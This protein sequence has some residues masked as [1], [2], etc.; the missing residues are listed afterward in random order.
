[1]AAT[2]VQAFSGDLDIA[3]A[4]T[5]NLEV[6][7]ANLFVDTVSGRVGIGV[8]NPVAAFEVR[9]ADMDGEAVGT[10]QVI[11]RFSAGNDGILNV[12]AVATANG[13]ETL[14]LQTQID[15]RAFE[16]DV[17]GGWDYGTVSRHDFVLQ[18]YKG[19]VGIG[20]TNPLTKLYIQD[21]NEDTKVT[22]R[23]GGPTVN[24]SNVSI[25]MF[26][27]ASDFYGGMIQYA[28]TGSEQGLRLGHFVNSATPRI[29]M[30]IDRDTGYVGV[31][32]HEPEVPLDVKSSNGSTNARALQLRAGDVTTNSDSFQIL[33]G[34]AG[35]STY[36]HGISSNH[37]GSGG[38]Y[39]QLNFWTW[40][41]GQSTTAMPT[42]R[43]MTLTGNGR[44]G[45]NG[46]P[47]P[48]FN[49]D[50]N[51]SGRVTAGM[52]IDGSRY[53][54]NYAG[55]ASSFYHPATIT[56][57]P[58][59][60]NY[61]L[62]L[63]YACRAQAYV[64]YSDRR[65][66]ENIEDIDDASALETL[67]RLKPKKYTYKDTK[68]RGTTPVWGFIAQEVRETLP[69]ATNLTVDCI[70]NIYELANVSQSNVI[71]F[72]NFNTSNFEN[73][74]P[75]LKL[76]TKED[77]VEYA[78]VTSII[79]GYSVSVDKDLSE[80]SG[81][82]DEATSNVV[83]GDKIFVYGEEVS[84]FVALNKDAIFTVATSAVQELDR[85]LQ[86]E[87]VKISTLETQLASVLTRLD[88]LEGA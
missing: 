83:T 73:S 14:G 65:I 20:T 36:R 30:K 62:T 32:V 33:F 7:T 24:N 16:T 61:T 1:M 48:S 3:G 78:N 22:I 56:V 2:N 9:A 6:G 38:T 8:T 52:Y 80:W 84:D 57:N 86:A 45:I 88:T 54:A 12:F 66:K 10:S 55:E 63:Q 75:T 81:Q 82:Y 51:G 60:Y 79:D 72:T 41:S 77:N 53:T 70:P 74:L 76:M 71:T 47:A 40:Q 58:A 35:T 43:T 19:N 11:S 26:E 69:H 67:R 42:R 87:K 21:E 29:D 31:G 4:I 37:D 34:Y 46:K 27:T 15:G 5:S 13:E 68:N 39:S 64:A 49:L 85:Q 25:E 50:V 28:G 59:N 44:C 18:P 17:S 23:G